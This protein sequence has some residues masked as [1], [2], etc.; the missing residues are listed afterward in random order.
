MRPIKRRKVLRRWPPNAAPG[1]VQLPHF[2]VFVGDDQKGEGMVLRQQGEELVEVMRKVCFY[3]V[4]REVVEERVGLEV[5]CGREKG[6]SMLGVEEGTRWL[7]RKH[8]ED[9]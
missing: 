9:G 4:E 3:G 8:E 6:G 2:R 7:A 1:S 5:L